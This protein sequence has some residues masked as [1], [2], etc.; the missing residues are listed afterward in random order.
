MKLKSTLCAML[1]ATPLLALAEGD[2]PWLPIPG[3]FSLGVS[4]TRQSGDYA[5]IGDK[6]TSLTAITNGA[7]DKFERSTTSL[8]LG[9]GISDSLAVDAT[10][11]W[12]D[13][14]AGD[15]DSDNGMLDSVI[16]L[17]WRVLDEL[18][19][20]GLFTLTLRSAVILK[21]DYEGGRLAGLGN[22]ANGYELAVIT[23]KQ[24]TPS[25]SVT[26]E[27]GF[28]DRDKDVPN[29][30]FLEL[31]TSYRF[32][33]QWVGSL[34]YGLKRYGGHLDIGGPGFSPDKFQQ[35]REERDVVKVGVG[36]ALAGNQA[37]GLSVGKLLRGR[38]TTRD[39]YIASLNYTYGF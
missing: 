4:H 8:R 11:G 24:L 27:A 33:P 10:I 20:P 32:A 35:V 23:G 17:N 39:D 9:Y 5:Y 16:G 34:G 36:Y 1:V 26:A 22:G 3:Q 6:K 2:S 31:G 14:K 29:A 37:L 28:Q 12:G 15:A 38:N 18:E 30:T 19:N 21:G 7:G 13:V 25:W